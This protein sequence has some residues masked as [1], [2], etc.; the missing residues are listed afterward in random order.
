[1]YGRHLS[2]SAPKSLGLLIVKDGREYVTLRLPPK[3]NTP[4]SRALTFEYLRCTT[5]TIPMFLIIPTR[6]ECLNM[7]L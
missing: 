1:M 2:T 5:P 3:A 4:L 6:P 7:N